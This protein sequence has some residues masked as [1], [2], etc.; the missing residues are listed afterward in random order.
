MNLE[1]WIKRQTKK[2]K[3]NKLTST[4]LIAFGFL[5]V[6]L[7]G[8]VLL[9]LPCMNRSGQW[10]PFVDALFMATTSVCVT[11]LS[12]VNVY[13][14]WTLPGQMVILILIQIGGI[15]VVALATLFFMIMGKKVTL[16]SRLLLQ[17]SYNTNSLAGLVRMT[18]RI[19]FGIAV[20]EGI[21]AVLYCLQFIPQYGVLRGIWISV[22]NSVSA[23][24]NAGMDVMG[25]DSLAAYVTNPFINMITMSLIVLGGIGFFVWWDVI[26]V[27]RKWRK[28]GIRN[29]AG[30]LNL[31]TKIVLVTTTALILIGAFFIF[32]LE[33]T[34]PDTLGRLSLG[35]KIQAALFQSVTTRTAGFSSV[36]QAEL[37]ESSALIS[38]ILMFIGG[39]PVG[40]AGGVKTVTIALIGACTISVVKGE[41]EAIV[42]RRTIPRETINRALAVFF[43][44][45]CALV[46]MVLLMSIAQ[47]APLLTIVYEV[48]S[49]LAT[50]GLSRNFTAMLNPAA[51]LIII[52]CMYIGRIG[53][54]SMVIAFRIKG[55]K[56]NKISYPQEEVIV[57]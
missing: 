42:F 50:V 48:V 11:G 23:F 20:I 28:T 7:L 34:N 3:E 41:K 2:K 37:R 9:M 36:N 54:I 1:R 30:K 10:T 52:F 12:L 17:E 29:C 18:R 4:Q 40:T 8:T 19:L 31:H 45:A 15:G 35:G 53:P 5:A 38:M 55:R 32:L 6:I 26:D 44:S 51:K 24:C 22:F 47:E 25:G 16:K 46:L 33:Y 14:Y 27:A 43:I 39:S 21:G 49:A 57:G 13:Q 56:K